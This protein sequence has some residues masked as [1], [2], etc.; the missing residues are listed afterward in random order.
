[1][2]WPISTLT[3][4]EDHSV[5]KRENPGVQQEHSWDWK[6][7]VFWLLNI[8]VMSISCNLQPFSAGLGALLITAGIQKVSSGKSQREM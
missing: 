1:M 4:S 6:S 5:S 7:G 3:S 2:L 8:N